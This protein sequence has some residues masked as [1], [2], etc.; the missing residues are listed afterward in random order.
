[1]PGRAGL[2][3]AEINRGLSPVLLLFFCSERAPG[4]DGPVD[5][6]VLKALA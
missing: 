5:C 4:R 6:R 2:S 3:L 1:M